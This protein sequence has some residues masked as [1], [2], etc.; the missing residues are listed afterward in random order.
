MISAQEARIRGAEAARLIRGKKRKRVHDVRPWARMRL[1]SKT[2]SA[3]QAP[4]ARGPR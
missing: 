4:K 2:G 1:S 3:A